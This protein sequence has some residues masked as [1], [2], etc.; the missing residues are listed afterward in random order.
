MKRIVSWVLSVTFY[1]FIFTISFSGAW[2]VLD[3]FAKDE[4]PKEIKKIEAESN[5]NIIYI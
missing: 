5:E 3:Y 1:I 4:K 2:A